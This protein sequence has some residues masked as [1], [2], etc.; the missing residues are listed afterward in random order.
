MTEQCTVLEIDAS[1]E[2]LWTNVRKSIDSLTTEYVVLTA[3]GSVFLDEDLRSACEYAE[4]EHLDTVMME[5]C[6]MESTKDS[7]QGSIRS[8]SII[9]LKKQK[10]LISLP[11]DY[12]EHGNVEV[13]KEETGISASIILKKV[14]AAALGQNP[15]R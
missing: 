14:M 8:G 7:S 3:K 15:E 9:H 13:L 6:Y 11:D 5:C 2:N 12:I 10:E 4:N 1:S